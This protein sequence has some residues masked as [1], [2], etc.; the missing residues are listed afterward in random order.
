MAG[1]MDVSRESKDSLPTMLVQAIV[2]AAAMCVCELVSTPI[3]VMMSGNAFT[4]LPWFLVADLFAVAFTYTVGFVLLWAVESLTARLDIPKLL[5]FVYALAGLIGFA[6]WGCAVYPAVIDSII[7]PAH[8]V[9]LTGA[10]RFGIGV[11]CAAAGFVA[12]FFGAILPQ[13]VAERRTAVIAVGVATLVFAV[14]G[15]IVYGMTL[16]AL[17]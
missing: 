11:N 13:R 14:L 9:A 16:S 8:G 17:S 1:W 7:V 12:F 4:A 2:I 15:G 5:P 6:A 10:A 3:Y